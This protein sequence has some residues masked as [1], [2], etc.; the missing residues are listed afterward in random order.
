MF[1]VNHLRKVFDRCMSLGISLNPKKSILGVFEGKLLG[2]I[3]SKEGVRIDPER[4][5]GIMEIPLPSSRKGILSFFGR[6]NFVRWFM[7]NFAE[8]AKPISDM[9]KKDHDLMW[10]DKTK[11]AF[12]DIKQALSHSPVLIILKIFKFSLFL[13]IQLGLLCYCRKIM[14]D[15]SNP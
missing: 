6:I 13:L 8:I 4:V 2:H 15:W 7:P 11:K 5:K 9:L 1:I 10:S 3:V 12:D 14:M